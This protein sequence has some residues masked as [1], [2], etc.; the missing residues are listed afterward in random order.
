MAPTGRVSDVIT[1]TPSW[2]LWPLVLCALLAAAIIVWKLWELSVKGGRT[3]R[4]LEEVDALVDRR[5]IAEALAAARGSDTPGGR[6]LGSGLSRRAA[7]SDRVARSMDNAGAIEE[8]ALHLWLTPL[9]AIA[10]VAPLLGFLGATLSAMHALDANVP[11]SPA[12][13]S[14]LVPAAVG[15]AIAIPVAVM[16]HYLVAR[17]ER[18]LARVRESALRAVDAVHAMESDSGS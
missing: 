14:A 1:T 8:A 17:I 4:L 6:M 5:M 10:A 9:A 15:L 12:I 2:T 13:A 18:L 3:M 7:G 11:V 16:H